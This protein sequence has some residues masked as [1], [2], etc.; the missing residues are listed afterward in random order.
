MRKIA[1]I[2]IIAKIAGIEN[3]A[4]SPWPLALG[5]WL[6][7]KATATA[8][9]LGGESTRIKGIDLQSNHSISCMSWAPICAKRISVSLINHSLGRRAFFGDSYIGLIS[10]FTIYE[11]RKINNADAHARKWF[12]GNIIAVPVA[13]TQPPFPASRR[14]QTSTQLIG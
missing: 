14:V 8:K 2:A 10:V 7:A 3:L 4:L 5:L 13:V 11:A 6:T 9:A 1:K 12:A